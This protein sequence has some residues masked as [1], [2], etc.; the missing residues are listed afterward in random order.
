MK[1]VVLKY[2]KEIVKLLSC[3]LLIKISLI[4]IFSIGSKYGAVWAASP[5]NV[6]SA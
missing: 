4:A 1:E 5:S 2:L 3:A 6:S